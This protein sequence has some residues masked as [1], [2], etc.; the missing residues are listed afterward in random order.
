MRKGVKNVFNNRAIILLH[1]LG[2]SPDILG[3]WYYKNGL[4]SSLDGG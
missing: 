4:Y 1:K 3:I 2:V